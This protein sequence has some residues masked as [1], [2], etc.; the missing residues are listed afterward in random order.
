MVTKFQHNCKR[1]SDLSWFIDWPCVGSNR[2]HGLWYGWEDDDEHR[3]SEEGQGVG[4][5]QVATEATSDWGLHHFPR[6]YIHFRTYGLFRN[7]VARHPYNKFKVQEIRDWSSCF[8]NPTPTP[9]K[10]P[11][12]SL[13][14]SFI[15]QHRLPFTS[16]PTR[17][18]IDI[19]FGGHWIYDTPQCHHIEKLVFQIFFQVLG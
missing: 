12:E 14:D 19:V 3:T 9:S 18:T 15:R 17:V 13:D 7:R 6:N 2:G 5:M 11:S 8:G 1:R 10:L 16:Y 4:W